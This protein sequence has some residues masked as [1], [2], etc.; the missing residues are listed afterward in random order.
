LFF[1]AAKVLWFLTQPSS[2]IALAAIAGAVLS[3][4]AAWQRL[5][6]RLLWGALAAVLIVGLSPLG[7]VLIR[8]L[9]QRFPRADID[10]GAP[11][12]GIIVLGGAEDGRAAGDAQELAGLN[13][14]AERY[15]E[16]AAL[17]RRLPQVRLVF[18]GGVGTLLRRVPPEA[19]SAGRLFAALGIA[20]E[21]L[22]LEAQ[23]RDTYENAVFSAKLLAPKAGERW[24]LITSAWHMPRA[25][26]CFRRAGFA[27]EAWPVDYRAPPAASLVR[28]NDS[29]PDGLR[30]V[31][32]VLREYVGLAAYYL[33]GRTDALFPAP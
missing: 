1:I 33:A 28:I 10:K 25:M 23:S 14:A 16:A 18:S 21:R 5:G 7:D 31:D 12:A 20:P 6:R 19:E 11:I 15:T 26:A 32:F 4:T 17:A 22:V 8:P 13:E 29:L 9:E 3:A 27:V 2:L 24:L 30:R